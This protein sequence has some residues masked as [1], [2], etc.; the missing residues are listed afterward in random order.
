MPGVQTG[1]GAPPIPPLIDFCPFFEIEF[2]PLIFEMFFNII[3]KLIIKNRSD[4][5]LTASASLSH[6]HECIDI[7]SSAIRYNSQA[8]GRYIIY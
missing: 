5:L 2:E 4:K 6:F 1:T 8:S 3:F 7:I